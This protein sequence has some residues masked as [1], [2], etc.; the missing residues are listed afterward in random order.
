MSAAVLDNTDLL[1]ACRTAPGIL[2][3]AAHSRIEVDTVSGALPSIPNTAVHRS[4]SEVAVA[5]LLHKDLDHCNSFPGF[6]NF[7]APL[8]RA[9]LGDTRNILGIG[10]LACSCQGWVGIPF[11]V[12]VR[13]PN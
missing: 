6:Q 5:A 1:L 13:N 10:V 2:P 7:V 11:H 12:Q 3:T 4:D 9:V 8:V